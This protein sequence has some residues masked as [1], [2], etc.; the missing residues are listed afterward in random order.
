MTYRRTRRRLTGCT[1]SVSLLVKLPSGRLANRSSLIGR[2]RLSW[3]R[4]E[5]LGLSALLLVVVSLSSGCVYAT[6]RLADLADI[7]TAQCG[8]GL[9]LHAA[10]R[11]TDYVSIGMGAARLHVVRWGERH[12]RAMFAFEIGIPF[13]IPAWLPSIPA[14]RLDRMLALQLDSQSLAEDRWTRKLDVGVELTLA[15]VGVGA[16]VRVGEL[17][18]FVAGIVGMDPADDDSGDAEERAYRQVM[19]AGGRW[20]AGDPHVHALPADFYYPDISA[21]IGDTMSM[22]KKRGAEWLIFTPHYP[23]VESGGEVT[24]LAYF[25]PYFTLERDLENV[26]ES[27]IVCSAGVEWTADKVGHAGI[28]FVPFDILFK[29][30]LFAI[31]PPTLHSE[32]AFLIANHPFTRQLWL[33][34]VGTFPAISMD[35][36]APD[37]LQQF[38]ALEG[39]NFLWDLGERLCLV[40]AEERSLALTWCQ[41]DSMVMRSRRRVVVVGSSDNHDDWLTPATWIYSDRPLSTS[42]IE[43]SLRDGRVCIVND[44][45]C[46]F[47]ARGDT[48]SLWHGIGDRVNADCLVEFRWRGK[49]ELMIDGESLGRHYEGFQ[50]NIGKPGTFHAA[51]IVARGGYSN[52]IYINGP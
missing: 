52:Y 41:A 9:G 35:W 5:N 30:P 19:D 16:A 48:D 15:A 2:L 26:S 1:S 11:I 34:L 21:T 4:R 32:G 43:E 42:G 31:D 22:A 12:P 17:V 3:R 29:R 7:V 27:G 20:F 38:D 6:D 44:E 8:T 47:R 25:E 51:R 37:L 28:A 49:A 33:P 24:V 10:V 50:F 13:S 18:D 45:A 23:V 36:K 46:T 39:Y 14:G 40:P